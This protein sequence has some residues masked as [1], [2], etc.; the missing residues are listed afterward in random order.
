MGRLS[1]SLLTAA[2][3]LLLVLWPLAF[4][5]AIQFHQV[6]GLTC[7]FKY[8]ERF[9]FAFPGTPDHPVI[10]AVDLGQQA[11]LVLVSQMA[12]VPIDVL[13]TLNP[14]YNR[15]ATSPKG[16]WRVVLPLE[17]AELLQENLQRRDGPALMKWDQV[18]VENGDTL[19]AIA[20]RHNVPVSVLRSSNDIRGDLI[21]PGQKLRLPRDEQLLVDPLYAQAAAEL[22]KLQAG[23]ISADRVNHRVRPGESLSVIA[24]RYSVSV[25]DLQRW[26]NISDPRRLRA[27]QNLT[28]FYT[29]AAQGAPASGT[30]QHVVQRGDS[31]WSIARKYKVKVNDLQSWNALG[32]SSKIK[33]GQ[34]IRIEL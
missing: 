26:N 20:S 11:D 1:A 7:L 15:W 30:V 12:E 22:Q 28:V 31:L 23:L 33:P 17:S 21:R 27:G 13:F 25:K 8:P 18:V 6:L 9:N 32:S 34:S 2:A 4:P 3:V 19:S 29:P 5:E 14:G 24:R 10:T 16:P